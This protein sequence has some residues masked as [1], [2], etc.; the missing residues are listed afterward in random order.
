[1]NYQNFKIWTKL[2]HIPTKTIAKNSYRDQNRKDSV[3]SETQKRQVEELLVEFLDKFAKHGLDVA[4]NSK[5]TMKLTPENDQPLYPTTPI[6]LREELQVELALLKYFG[7]IP[8]LNHSK[9]CSPIFAHHKP[10]GKVRSL[11]DLQRINHLLLHDYHNNNFPISTMAD[12][13]THFTGKYFFCK[14]D[15]SQA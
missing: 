13:T 15:C 11:V 5:I 7:K 2:V 4:Y 12:I 10:Y 9:Y 3:L 1:M 14:L 8:S 6:H